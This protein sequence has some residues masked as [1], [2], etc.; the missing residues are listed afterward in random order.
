MCQSEGMNVRKSTVMLLGLLAGC[1]GGATPE[2]QAVTLPSSPCTTI[3]TPQ[4]FVML[5]LS[6]PQTVVSGTAAVVTAAGV[7][8]DGNRKDVTQE[9]TW[10]S[11]NLLSASASDGTV[12]GI[13]AGAVTIGARLGEVSAA[14]DV[15]VVPV[16]LASLELRAD[17]EV[18]AAGAVSSWRVIGHYNDTS[19]ADLTAHADWSTSDPSVAAI[20]GP[21]QV[22]AVGSGMAMVTAASD[23]LDASEPMLVQ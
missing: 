7:D 19:T 13:G 8:A 22:R 18:A 5:V 10:T 14:A 6:V 15:T 1:A 20:D 12:Y 4:P 16:A 11:S 3:T 9:V 21:G 2:S 17:S 23:G